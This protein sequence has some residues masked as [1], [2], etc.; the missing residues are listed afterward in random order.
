M[1]DEIVELATT[2]SNDFFIAFCPNPYEVYDLG[3]LYAKFNAKYFNGELPVVNPKISENGAKTYSK[4]RWD[5]RLKR[6]WGVYRTARK[7]GDGVISLSPTC[8]STPFQVENTLLHEMLHKWL[9][10][11]GLDDG[12]KGHGPNFTQNASRINKLC[13]SLKVG[14]RIQFFDDSITRDLPVASAPILER[15]IACSDD[16]DISRAMQSVLRA[17]FDKKYEYSL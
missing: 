17:A 11:K 14:Y 12:I 3:E 4:L 1:P 16:L 2:I 10:L 9:D 7:P 13:Q 6:C 5:K 8:V 15:T